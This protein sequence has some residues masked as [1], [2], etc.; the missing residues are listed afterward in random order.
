MPTYT[1]P[2]SYSFVVPSGV[3][4]ITNVDVAGGQGGTDWSANAAGGLGGRIAIT[5][6]VV[7]P[8][9]TITIVVGGQGTQGADGT[10]NGSGAAGS[11]ALGGNAAGDG[12]I[13][14]PAGEGRSG[15][16]GGGGGSAIAW[17]SGGGVQ[18]IASGGGGAGGS[19]PGTSP[20]V[21]YGGAGGAGGPF[22]GGYDGEGTSGTA[23]GWVYGG[24]TY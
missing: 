8:G 17:S 18:F 11:G 20:A 22:S 14:T 3:T 4:E 6:L 10:D 21:H 19:H 15:G 16:G 1:T 24:S 2:G 7:V 5:T 9:T 13:V 23:E 12:G